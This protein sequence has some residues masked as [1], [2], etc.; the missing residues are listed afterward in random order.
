MINRIHIL[1]ASGSGT[2]TLAQEISTRLQY[3]HFDTDNYFWIKTDPPFTQK[4]EVKER[5]ELLTKDLQAYDKWVLSGSLCGWGDVFIPFFDL[6]VYLW[7]PSDIRLQRL[8]AREYQ[9]YGDRIKEGGPLHDSHLDFIDWASRYDTGGM[10][11]RSKTLHNSWLEQVP[12]KVIRIEGDL[13]LDEKYRIVEQ[14]IT[15]S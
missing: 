5:I 1:G 11:I 13:T 2:T 6:V 10:D 9:R 8:K 4:R 15:N 7:I 3:R 12:C 14:A